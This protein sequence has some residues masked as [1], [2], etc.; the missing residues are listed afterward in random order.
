MC[1]INNQSVCFSASVMAA[2]IK[3]CIVIVLDKFFK[4]SF[5]EVPGAVTQ[6]VACPLH[7]QRSRDRSSHPAYSFVGK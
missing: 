4:H 2:S 3:P 6:S 1:I 5:L 7:K